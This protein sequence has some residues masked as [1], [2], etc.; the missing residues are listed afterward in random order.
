MRTRVE[1]QLVFHCVLAVATAIAF[2]MGDYIEA[3]D[4]PHLQK[5][6]HTVPPTTLE[7][8]GIA[9]CSLLPV[10]VVELVKLIQRVVAKN[11]GT[12]RV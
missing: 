10:V 7:W 3:T 6:L 9:G 2:A 12:S 8:G 4:V 11:K 1:R 5:V